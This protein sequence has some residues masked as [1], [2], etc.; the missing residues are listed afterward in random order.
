MGRYPLITKEIK[1]WKIKKNLLHKGNYRFQRK[2]EIFAIFEEIKRKNPIEYEIFKNEFILKTGSTEKNIIEKLNILK[3]NK[4]IKLY[5]N[6]KNEN[7]VFI[8]IL[9]DDII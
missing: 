6:E 7:K 5:K 8:K 1:N 3:S 9:K 2:L 4:L